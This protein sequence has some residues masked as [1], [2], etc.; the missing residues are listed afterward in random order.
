MVSA[1]QLIHPASVF[2]MA[3]HRNQGWE[4]V[5]KYVWVH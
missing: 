1:S 4:L 3:L 5:V 2:S